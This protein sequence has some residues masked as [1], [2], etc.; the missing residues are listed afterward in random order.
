MFLVFLK[1]IFYL[2]LPCLPFENIFRLILKNIY[3]I[4]IK[5]IFIIINIKIKHMM[6][7]LFQIIVRDFYLKQILSYYV[8]PIKMFLLIQKN[9]WVNG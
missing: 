1:S 3:L 2:E 8:N 9:N 4:G 6:Q 7:L 5:N